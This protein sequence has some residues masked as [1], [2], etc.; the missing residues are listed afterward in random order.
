MCWCASTIIVE[1]G[2]PDKTDRAKWGSLSCDN[3]NLVIIV[4]F[5]FLKFSREHGDK[6]RSYRPQHVMKFIKCVA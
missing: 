1:T 3:C 6:F 5:F 2:L 4:I